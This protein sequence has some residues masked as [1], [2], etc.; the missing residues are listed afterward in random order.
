MGLFAKAK[1]WPHWFVDEAPKIVVPVR[2][3]I[4]TSGERYAIAVLNC[5][6]DTIAPYAEVVSQH[7][8][9]GLQEFRWAGSLAP[10]F[11]G[12]LVAITD[13]RDLTKQGAATVAARY[14]ERAGA[15]GRVPVSG[16]RHWW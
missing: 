5:E 13:I 14:E 9:L 1:L 11:M 7:A 12:C 4:D 2:L 10:R 6:A 3:L 15:S 8:G 16:P